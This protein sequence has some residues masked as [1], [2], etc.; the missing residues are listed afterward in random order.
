MNRRERELVG[1]LN[2][3]RHRI[4]AD[5]KILAKE[6]LAA[7]GL[8]VPRTLAVIEEMRDVARIRDIVGCYEHFVIKPARGRAGSGIAVLGPKVEDGW[9]SSSRTV[10]DESDIRHL[11]GNILLGEYAMR[12]WDRALIE[13]RVITGPVLE[14]VPTVGL[15]DIRVITLHGETVMS[16]V[17]F[18]TRSSRGKANLHLGALGIGVDLRTGITTGGTWRSRSVTRH[19][20]TNHPLAGLKVKAWDEVVETARRAARVF[21]LG[22]LGIDIVIT[23]EGRPVVLEVNVRPGL[24]I[25][26]ANQRGLRPEISRVLAALEGAGRNGIEGAARNEFGEPA[27]TD[28]GGAARNEGPGGRGA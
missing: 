1:D 28:P 7:D 18:P 23:H 10:W 17:R 25:Q 21:P 26:N 19:P 22:Y 6:L 12:T 15:P 20:E 16:M 8:P 27:R 9:H 13:E 3:R 2:P 5:D 4:L 24:E 11:L 14:E